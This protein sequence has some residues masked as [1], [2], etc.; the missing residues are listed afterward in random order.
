ML[1]VSAPLKTDVR[2]FLLHYPRKLSKEKKKKE[3]FS[4]Q[5]YRKSPSIVTAAFN[6]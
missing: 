4:W 2:G 6:K 1:T 5:F 3:L